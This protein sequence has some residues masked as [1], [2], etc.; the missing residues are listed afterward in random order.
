MGGY[1]GEEGFAVGK[2]PTFTVTFVN[3][4]KLLWALSLASTQALVLTKT[5]PSY[6]RI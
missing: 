3:T 6:S 5:H 4:G 2:T 1:F